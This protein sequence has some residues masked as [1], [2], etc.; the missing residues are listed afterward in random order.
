MHAMHVF[1]AT[2]LTAGTPRREATEAD[3]ITARFPLAQFEHMIRDGTIK[4]AL[5]VAAY[6]LLKLGA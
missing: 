2:D 1:V 3:M 4:D 6:G 5:S